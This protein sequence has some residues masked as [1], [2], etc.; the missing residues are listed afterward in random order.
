[1]RT[2]NVEALTQRAEMLRPIKRAVSERIA[3]A[4]LYCLALT[5]VDLSSVIV[6]A[7]KRKAMIHAVDTGETFLPDGGIE[8][9]QAAMLAWEHGRRVG[10]TM[11]AREKGAVVS[12]KLMEERRE[13]AL[14]IAQPLW[15]LPTAEITGSEIA[16]RTGISVASLITH[17]GLRRKAQ[18]KHKRNTQND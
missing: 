6:A 13:R 2:R 7:A 3:V 5:A 18:E 8:D 17:L 4:S 16:K 11:A 15:G 10:Q 9:M 14:E 1:M 12:A